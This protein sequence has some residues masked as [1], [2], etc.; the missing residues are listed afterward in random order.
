M[1]T[2]VW[3]CDFFHK[4]D[5][6]NS[7]NTWSQG[8]AA[9]ELSRKTGKDSSPELALLQTSHGQMAAWWWLNEGSRKW[10]RHQWWLN[11]KSQ[12]GSATD[13][14]LSTF[15]AVGNQLSYSCWMDA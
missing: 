6:A 1:L 14:W 8:H 15:I 3:L 2:C 4:A 12:N 9:I 11:E 5:G 13:K 10:K 7:K